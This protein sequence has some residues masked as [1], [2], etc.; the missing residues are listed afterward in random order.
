MDIS[1]A[2]STLLYAALLIWLLFFVEAFPGKGWF[3]YSIKEVDLK[4]RF[5][6]FILLIAGMFSVFVDKGVLG[7][8][9]SAIALII[10]IFS[11]SS[12]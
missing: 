5:L 1:I 6:C 2:I 3:A 9:L 12:S 10:L 7:G 8:I 4:I 11:A